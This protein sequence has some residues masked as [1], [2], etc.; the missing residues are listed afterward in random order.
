[1]PDAPIPLRAASVVFA[2]IVAIALPAHAQAPSGL[3]GAS[4]A[5]G[6]P[7]AAC[8]HEPD[9]RRRLSCYDREFDR[10]D[11]AAAA[12]ATTNATANATANANADAAQSAP[13]GK[14]FA[15][16]AMESVAT[17][18]AVAAAHPAASPILAAATPAST[19]PSAVP[20]APAASL[21]PVAPKPRASA[22]RLALFHATITE[23]HFRGA[24]EFVI[25]LDNGQVWTQYTAE[26]KPRIAVGDRV[27]IRPGW[28]GTYILSAPSE[29]ITK[30]H[31][32]EDPSS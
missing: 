8:R 17:A 19:P 24:G 32:V 20:A 9:D 13:A 28:L 27:T 23:M 18:P 26:G 21:A 29:W 22:P 16:R 30:V 3:P 12:N 4:P 10:R 6:D 5:S 15:P 7:W 31:P 25:T 2:S 14:S 11:A 1:M